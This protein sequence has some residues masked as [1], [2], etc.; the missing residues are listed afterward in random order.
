MYFN[1]LMCMVTSTYLEISTNTMYQYVTGP[2]ALKMMMHMLLDELDKGAISV[3]LDATEARV[4]FQQDVTFE[5]ADTITDDQAWNQ[6]ATINH[7]GDVEELGFP[8]LFKS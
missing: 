4:R 3:Y 2:I 8:Q 7:H 6:F 5:C 1:K